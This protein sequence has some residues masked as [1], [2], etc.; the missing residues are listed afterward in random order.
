[1]IKHNIIIVGC[2]AITFRWLD[3][4]TKRDDCKVLALVD[5]NVDNAI[6]YRDR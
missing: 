2:G 6:K 5:R 3:H 1:M 4:I